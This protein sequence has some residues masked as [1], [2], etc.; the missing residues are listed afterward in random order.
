VRLFLFF[1]TWIVIPANQFHRSR[2]KLVFIAGTKVTIRNDE[3]QLIPQKKGAFQQPLAR[4][5]VGVESGVRIID[6]AE[7][8]FA[9]LT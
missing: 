6:C 4:Q 9:L 2:Y 3:L 8:I 5:S 1:V 7:H